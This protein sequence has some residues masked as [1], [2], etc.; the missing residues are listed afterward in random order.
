MKR[1]F[2]K[3]LANKSSEEYKARKEEVVDAVRNYFTLFNLI[4]MLYQFI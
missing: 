3:E 1:D 2:K 4:H